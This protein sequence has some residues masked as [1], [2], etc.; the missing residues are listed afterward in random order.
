MEL[1]Q[2][3]FIL[4]NIIKSVYNILC[5]QT[6]KKGIHVKSAIH[7]DIPLY[8]L[9]DD[10][11][12]RQIL[13]KLVG[14]AIKFTD[15]GCISISAAISK[16]WENQDLEL[17]ISV[18]DTGIGI[19]SSRLN[20]L[21][22]PFTQ[23]D[24]SISR[25]Y[26]GT[27]LGLA[28]SKSL[29]KLMGGTIWVESRGEIGGNPPL[30]WISKTKNDHLQGSTFHFTFITK[31]GLVCDLISGNTSDDLPKKATSVP[32]SITVLL[33]EDNKVNQKVALYSLKKIGYSA[34]IANNGVEVLEMLE[35]QSYDVILMDMQ[36]PEM[37]GITATRIIR[38]S[39]NPQPWIIAITA[40]IL[41]EDRHACFN[42]GMNDFM[43]KPIRVEELAAVI[44][45]AKI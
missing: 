23:A 7:A 35:K 1:E 8:I 25:K 16:K 30:N 11:R 17:M 13:I 3:S 39:L 14:N 5:T 22:Q 20:K 4:K 6:L 42:A 32:S 38:Q 28:I 26:G 44:E 9:G 34:D 29:V 2:R 41:E 37:D 27:G 36:M 33:A 24:N 15:Q 40:N 43:T 10:S 19:D 12:L 31:A 18:Q 21:F 45:K